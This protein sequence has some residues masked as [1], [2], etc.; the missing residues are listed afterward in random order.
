MKHTLQ[1]I[2]KGEIRN[3]NIYYSFED[4]RFARLCLASTDK[5]LC[6]VNLILEGATDAQALESLQ[7]KFPGATIEASARPEHAE[8]LK[9]LDK[10]T[11]SLNF[12]LLGTSFQLDVWKALV[13]IPYGETSTYGAIAAKIGRPKAF[14]AVGSAVGDNPIYYAVPCHRV[15]PASGGIGQFYWGPEIKKA[16]LDWEKLT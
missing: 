1:P 11:V 6:S 8:F 12:H 5:G 2:L 16:L 7:K 3:L 4:S 13:E 10:K 14:R 9:F 15:L